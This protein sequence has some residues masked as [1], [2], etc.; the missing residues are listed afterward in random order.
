MRFARSLVLLAALAAQGCAIGDGY[1]NRYGS[2]TDYGNQY[3]W[4]RTTCQNDI[5]ASNVEPRL[6]QRWM[7]C[8]MWRYGVPLDDNAGCTAPP[9]YQG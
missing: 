7:Q 4:Q 5:V 6:R 9:Y 1:G 3:A 8:C 2:L